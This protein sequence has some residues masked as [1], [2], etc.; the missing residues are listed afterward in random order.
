MKGAEGGIQTF[1][2]WRY[3]LI[4]C[5]LIYSM[6]VV[7]FHASPPSKHSN[8]LLENHS[9][10]VIQQEK[11]GIILID[12]KKRHGVFSFNE[13]ITTDLDSARK[14]YGELLGWSFRETRSLRKSLFPISFIYQYLL[15]SMTISTE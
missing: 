10:H 9:T 2:N 7:H 6:R 13:L 11:R 8:L 3:L 14:F 5:I 1:D 12:E 4:L 15:D